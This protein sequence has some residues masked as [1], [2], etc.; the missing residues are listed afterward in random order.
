MKQGSL[1]RVVFFFWGVDGNLQLRDQEL[2]KVFL[3][4]YNSVFKSN[5][6]TYIPFFFGSVLNGTLPNSKI[7]WEQVITSSWSWRLCAKCI[8]LVSVWSCTSESDQLHSRAI[9]T[10]YKEVD[11]YIYIYTCTYICICIHELITLIFNTSSLQCL[12][13]ITCTFF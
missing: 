13:I 2:C 8:S 9:F 6:S 5:L 11:K 12:R 3:Y 10:N 4:I 1:W 7:F